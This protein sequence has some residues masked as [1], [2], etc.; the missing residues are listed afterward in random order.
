M[1]GS[2]Y[3][4]DGTGL[5]MLSACQ[6]ARTMPR[7]ILVVSRL[8]CQ[9]PLGWRAMPRTAKPPRQKSDVAIP[10]VIDAAGVLVVILFPSSAPST[11]PRRLERTTPET[12]SVSPL[13]RL[14]SIAHA[15]CVI[16]ASVRPFFAAIVARRS[17]VLKCYPNSARRQL[18]DVRVRARTRPKSAF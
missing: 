6:T 1:L 17:L 18:G 4:H 2:D 9:P 10:S 14:S 8:P 16:V 15:T 11:V 13:Y 12:T 3:E 7:Y 5:S